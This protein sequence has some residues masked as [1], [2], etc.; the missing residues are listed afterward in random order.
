MWTPLKVGFDNTVKAIKLSFTEL[1]KEL[2]MKRAEWQLTLATA[3]DFLPGFDN[4]RAGLEDKLDALTNEWDLARIRLGEIDLTEGLEEAFTEKLALMFQRLATSA[5]EFAEATTGAF[6]GFVGAIGD[7]K[8]APEFEEFITFLDSF[9]EQV[10]ANDIE[11]TESYETELEKRL[12]ALIAFSEKQ[13]RIERE[14]AAK[15]KA[16]EASKIDARKNYASAAVD[17]AQGLYTFSDENNRSMFDI[18]KAARLSQAFINTHAGITTALAE[19]NI[20]LAV[21]IGAQGFASVAAIAMTK[22]GGGSSANT[23]V[24]GDTGAGSGSSQSVPDLTSEED[25]PP[26]QVTVIIN[27]PLATENWDEITENQIAPALRRAGE[28]DVDIIV[29][30]G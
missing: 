21:A 18:L 10:K 5:P 11:L 9:N 20:P 22:F 17:I 24:S 28:R 2:Q 6:K 3:V 7:I 23:T 30:G 26:Q 15:A 19:G 13:D 27:S 14:K 12:N 25:A 4:I 29:T 1:I 8:N 16:L